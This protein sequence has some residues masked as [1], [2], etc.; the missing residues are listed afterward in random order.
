MSPYHV[1]TLFHEGCRC[2]SLCNFHGNQ[3]V[4]MF[5]ASLAETFSEIA[6]NFLHVMQMIHLPSECSRGSSIEFNHI[7]LNVIVHIVT[8]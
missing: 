5:H 4:F 8:R 1:T 2:G 3:R 7:K 6:D